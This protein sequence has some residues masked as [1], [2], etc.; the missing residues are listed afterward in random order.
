MKTSTFLLSAALLFA[1]AAALTANSDFTKFEIQVINEEN[2][3]NTVLDLFFDLTTAP[4]AGDVLKG[5]L[6]FVGAA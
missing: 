5:R 3:A 1:S 6:D 4:A 2:P